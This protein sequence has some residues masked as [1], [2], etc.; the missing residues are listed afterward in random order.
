[1]LRWGLLLAHGVARGIKWKSCHPL[2]RHKR[3]N[4]EPTATEDHIYTCQH[5]IGLMLLNDFQSVH[6]ARR[7]YR[8]ESLNE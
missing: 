8:Y 5:T 7:I 6:L 4:V 1:M 3:Y 2:A